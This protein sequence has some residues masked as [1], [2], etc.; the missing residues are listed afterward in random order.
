MKRAN[1]LSLEMALNLK[2]LDLMKC[3]QKD[4]AIQGSIFFDVVG[5]AEIE[6]VWVE[7]EQICK[8][9]YRKI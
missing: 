9:Y 5:T 6:R 8:N 2:W 7:T 4:A 1:S 3:R